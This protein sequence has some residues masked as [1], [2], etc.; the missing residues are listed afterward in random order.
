MIEVLKVEPPDP[1][2]MEAYVDGSY[3]KSTRVYGAGCVI[4]YNGTYENLMLTGDNPLKA[5]MR[6]VAGEIDAAMLAM[7]KAYN[8]EGVKLLRIY[9]DYTGIAYWCTGKW[10]ANKLWTQLYKKH[11][12][13]VVKKIKIEFIKVAAHS[14]DEF[15]DC[16][17]YLAKKACGLAE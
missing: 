2:I 9:H 1:T 10:K 7:T 11:Y 3:N 14:G 6:N 15:N 8:T 13:D 4:I 5:S 12:E 16:A 17:D